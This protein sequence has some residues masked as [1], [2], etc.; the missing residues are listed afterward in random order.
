[1]GA[2]TRYARVLGIQLRAS[3]SISMQYRFDFLVEGGLAVFWAVV[4]LV[5]ILVVFQQPRSI[6]GWSFEESLVVLGWFTLLRGVLEG[7]VNPSLTAVVNHV[8]KGTLDFVLLKPAD[9]QFLVS[10]GGFEP[11]RVFDGLSALAIWGYAFTRLGRW[12]T[13]GAVAASLVLLLASVVLLYS[14]W[15]VVVSMAFFAVRV[16]NLTYLFN[17]IFDAARWPSSVFKGAL[18][19]VFTYVFP[20]AL[21]T[22]VPAEALLGRLDGAATAGALG[23]AAVFAF[24]AR[25][26]WKASITRYTSAGG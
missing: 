22:T 7:A 2:L 11:W 3:L 1:M 21:M 26:V 17:S 19:V 8:R 15:I 12:P 18:R 20:L 6:G 13:P 23:G 16:D 24:V 9:A 4:A 5:P 14:I 10:T 25:Q